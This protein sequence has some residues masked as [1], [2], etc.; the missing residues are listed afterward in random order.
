MFLIFT[1]YFMF[2]DSLTLLL[3]WLNLFLKISISPVTSDIKSQDTIFLQWDCES[4]HQH[5][6]LLWWALVFLFYQDVFTVKPT[7]RSEPASRSDEPDHKL[8]VMSDLTVPLKPPAPA[9]PLTHTL[10]FRSTHLVKAT[11]VLS[12]LIQSSCRLYSNTQT[13]SFLLFPLSFF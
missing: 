9:T 8:V 10:L 3:P 6:V 5:A 2:D 1:Y 13:V 7:A 4:W 12:L 11:L